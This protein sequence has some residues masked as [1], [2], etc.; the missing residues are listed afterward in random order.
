MTTIDPRVTAQTRPI[1]V[2]GEGMLE[3]NGAGGQCRLAY[4]GDTLNTAIHLARHGLPVRFMSALGTDPYS[5]DLIS[6]WQAEGID[7]SP[8]RRLPGRLPGLYAIR[9]DA[10]GER[11]FVYW[12]SASAARAMFDGEEHVALVET[13]RSAGLLYYSLITLAIL[14]PAAR[15]ILFALCRDVRARGGRV[16]FDGNYRPALWADAGEAAEVRDRAL[17]CA[18]IGLPTLVDEIGID[19]P[20]DAGQVAARWRRHGVDEVVV[21]LGAE[22]CLLNG[23]TIG[24]RTIRSPVDTSGA[25]DAFNAGY[26]AARMTGSAPM[27]AAQAGHALAGWVITRPGAIPPRSGDAPYPV[28]PAIR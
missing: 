7:T 20:T 27:A 26:L 4:G 16:A 23:A 6:A 5:H 28:P 21:K 17:A 15:E 19:G 11:E 13:A 3:L 12:R 1:C 25:G 14:P 8:I 22:G 18:D 24:P 10:A 2:I 9:L